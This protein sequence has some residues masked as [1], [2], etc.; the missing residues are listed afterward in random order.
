MYRLST[1]Y[2]FHNL[3]SCVYSLHN[4]AISISDYM[5]STG[6][7]IAV[8]RKDVDGSGLFPIKVL[9]RHLTGGTE[10]TPNY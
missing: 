8:Y 9:T 10:E 4:D 5:A 3:A 2:I 7:M 6:R 1:L